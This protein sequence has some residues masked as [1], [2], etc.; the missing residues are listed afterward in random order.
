MIDF[1]L[2]AE[3]NLDGNAIT[4]PVRVIWGTSD[5]LL[6]WP[7]AAA[8]YRT[9]WLPQADW[10]VLDDVGHYPQLDVP[11]GPTRRWRHIGDPFSFMAIRPMP[12]KENSRGIR[13]RSSSLTAA[14]PPAGTS[15]RRTGRSFHANTDGWV[16]L[17]DGV[18]G[19]HRATDILSAGNAAR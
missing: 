13:S 4:C 1:G 8:R 10:V 9:Q 6:P 7:Q 11:L 3:W 19:D 17:I 14:R 16:I 15:P 12:A 18:P 2:R 5:N